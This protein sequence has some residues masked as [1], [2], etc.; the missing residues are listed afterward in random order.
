MTSRRVMPRV[1]CAVL[2]MSV[3]SERAHA[4]SSGSSTAADQLFNEGRE[5]AKAGQWT[6]ACPKFEASLRLDPA[7]GTR[8]NLATCYEHLGKFARAW[9]LY[10][11]SVDLAKQAG[12]VRRRDYA[13]AHA[14]ALEPR[15]ARLV[16]TAPGKSLTGFVVRWDGS[17]VEAGA[18]GV[19]LYADA[20]EHEIIA[21]AP[22]FSGHGQD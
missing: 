2:V 15:L 8:L 14:D 10:R 11:E 18:L 17:P 5:L 21:S 1:R 12:D 3:V 7:L 6:K 22:G 19:G 9:R 20:G 16:I 4:Q 13:R